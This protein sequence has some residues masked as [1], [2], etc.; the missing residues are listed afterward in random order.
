MGQYAYAEGG[1]GAEFAVR[2]QKLIDS[3]TDFYSRD[4]LTVEE[5]ERR[6]E[7]ADRKSVV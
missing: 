3:L 5:Y 4:I 2:K 6:V 1:A 7:K